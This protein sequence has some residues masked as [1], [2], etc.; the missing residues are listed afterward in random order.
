MAISGVIWNSFSLFLVALEREFGWSRSTI[1]AA[2]TLFTILNAASAP[3][4]GWCLR[5]WDSRVVLGVASAILGAGFLLA[6][7]VSSPLDLYV[8]FGLVAGLGVQS[9]GTYVLFTILA[10]W[11]RRGAAPIMSVVDSGSGIGV[12]VGLPLLHVLMEGVGWRG[13]YLCLAVAVLGVVLPLNALFMRYAPPGAEPPPDP[14]QKRAGWKPRPGVVPLGAAFFLGPVA[15]HAL[16]T[17][18][19]ALFHDR[20]VAVGD[21]VWIASATGLAVFVCR[22]GA[23]WLADR[24]GETQVMRLACVAATMAVGALL[25]VVLGGPAGLLYVYPALVGLGFGAQ[26]ILLALGTRRLAPGADFGVVYGFLRLVA[27]AGMAIGPSLAAGVY[28]LT[29]SYAAALVLII[30][31]VVGQFLTFGVALR[32]G[33]E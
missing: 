31:A 21:A 27:G 6:A 2:Y 7:R 9:C 30:G 22:F 12:F 11:F 23:G 19:V 20:G 33:V 13:A 10:N 15:Y 32:R 1:S 5:R 4:I 16:L 24:W 25:A 29:G 3:L 14:P 28:D 17:Q 26:V 8:A 18:Q